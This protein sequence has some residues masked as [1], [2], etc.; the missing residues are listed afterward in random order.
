MTEKYVSNFICRSLRKQGIPRIQGNIFF[1][2]CTCMLYV[3]RIQVPKIYRPSYC[4]AKHL[5]ACTDLAIHNFVHLLLPTGATPCTLPVRRKSNYQR[6]I[7]H[8]RKKKVSI[9]LYD[10]TCIWPVYNSTGLHGN[11]WNA[12]GEYRNE[13]IAY[14]RL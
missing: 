9:S 11:H 3:N 13:Y 1:F 8:F 14:L 6:T 4:M 5:I 12:A 7:S 10:C 2:S